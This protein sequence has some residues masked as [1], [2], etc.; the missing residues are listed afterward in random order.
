M[1]KPLGE[2]PGLLRARACGAKALYLLATCLDASI[3]LSRSGRQWSAG[4]FE[5]DRR[6]NAICVTRLSRF[7]RLSSEGGNHRIVL[8]RWLSLFHDTHD[9]YPSFMRWPKNTNL[10]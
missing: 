3:D 7:R 6:S 5:G 10:M 9:S 8:R 1:E 2:S 4:Y